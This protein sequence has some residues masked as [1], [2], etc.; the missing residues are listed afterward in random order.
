MNALHRLRLSTAE[1]FRSRLSRQIVFWIFGSI[2]VIEGIILVPSVRRQR[3]EAEHQLEQTTLTAV[4]T[5]AIAQTIAEASSA[6]QSSA[7]QSFLFPD[8]QERNE[9]LI[10]A[11]EKSQSQSASPVVGITLYNVQGQT[12]GQ[13]GEA[14]TLKPNIETTIRSEWASRHR[15]EILLPAESLN[16]YYSVTLR[17]DG[18]PIHQNVYAFIGRIAGLVVIISGFVTLTTFLVLQKLII[19]PLQQIRQQ[20]ARAIAAD[21]PQDFY[22]Q[23]RAGHAGQ[24]DELDDVIAAFNQRTAQLEVQIKSTQQALAELKIAQTQMIQSEKMAGI[25]QLVAG[26]AHEINNPASFI[27]GNLHHIHSY[28]EDLL[29]VVQ[30]HRQK[31]KNLDSQDPDF[32][33]LNFTD[34]ELE[35]LDFIEQDWRK[36]INSMSSGAQ[37]IQAIVLS[38]RNF[39]RLDESDFKPADIHDGLDNALLLLNNRLSEPQGGITLT[40]HY[41]DLPNVSCFPSALNQV[42]LQLLNN[43]IDA[44]TQKLEQQKDD[45]YRAEIAITTAWE[46]PYTVIKIK[47]NGVGIE[48]EI[49]SKIFDPFFTTKPVGKGTGMGL[50]VSYQ[51]VVGRHEGHLRCQSTPSQGSEFVIEIPGQVQAS[52]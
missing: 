23:P 42:F 30:S 36:L 31:V 7:N 38:L 40:K 13:F 34:L 33:A 51:I 43:A 46:P 5:L 24:R 25:G 17:Y 12:V 1:V 45:S 37:R 22:L 32:K 18:T 27:Y 52:T 20:L 15:Y 11:I 49:Q 47:D 26:V 4:Q 41:Q 9:F 35:D 29:T 19:S 6:S 21:S 3:Q 39:A 10:R 44:V 50:A 8:D 14:V 16:W 28:F 48:P 2:L